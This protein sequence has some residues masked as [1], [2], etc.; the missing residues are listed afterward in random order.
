M[1]K[2][3]QLKIEKIVKSQV[4][5]MLKEQLTPLDKKAIGKITD[6]QVYR[7]KFKRELSNLLQQLEI[8]KL[9]ISNNLDDKNT[10][11]MINDLNK[12]YD[13]IENITKQL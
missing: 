1:K 12:S 5:K 7:K 8:I 3:T 9:D 11:K 6:T 4:T 13:I 10:N 2:E